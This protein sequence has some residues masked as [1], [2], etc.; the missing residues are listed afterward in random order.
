MIGLVALWLLGYTAYV[1]DT[2]ALQTGTHLEKTDAIIVFTGNK[3]RITE[4]LALFSEGRANELF[5]TSVVKSFKVENLSRYQGQSFSLPECCIT[6]DYMATSTHEN[7]IQ[8]RQWLDGK[9]V[10][11]VRLVTS[12]YHLRRSYA[13]LWN[14]TGNIEIITHP[15]KTDLLYRGG[16]ANWRLLLREYNKLLATHA[17]IKSGLWDH[18]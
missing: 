6:L 4:G 12:D 17:L 15:V 14:A 3:A 13:E 1:Y 8:A 16:K 18:Q 5:I 11:S 9:D 2:A 10:K 7:A